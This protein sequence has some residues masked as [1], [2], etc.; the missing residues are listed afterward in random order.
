MWAVSEKHSDVAKL[1]VERGA[2]VKARSYYVPSASGRGFEGTTPVAN[3]PAGDG[4]EEFASGWLTPLMLAARENDVESAKLL[5]KAGSDINAQSGDGKDA[6]SLALFDGSWDVAD[7]LLDS[8]VKVNQ[9][10]AQRFTPLF[11]AVD[12]RNMETR[13][14]LSVDGDTRSAAADQEVTGSGRGYQCPD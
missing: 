6:L 13:A 14:K 4:F 1:L 3:K 8:G 12:R 9:A 5:I 2:D 11:W 7:I 10:D